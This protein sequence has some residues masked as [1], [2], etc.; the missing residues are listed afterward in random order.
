MSDG[1]TP[2]PTFGNATRFN[3]LLAP[4]ERADV[5]IDFRG[6][7]N[8]NLILYGDA[9]APF[10]GG[11]IRNDYY[12]GVPDLTGIG[13]APTPGAGRSP[14]T[15]TIMQFRVGDS[16]GSIS[17]LDFAGTIAALQND[18]TG[19]PYVF[20]QSQPDLL[21]PTGKFVRQLT[22]NEGFD[23]WGRLIQRLGTTVAQPVLNN[24]GLTEYGIPLDDPPT[25]ITSVGQTEVWEIFNLTGD[26]HPIHFHLVNVQILDRQAFNV[27]TPD[28]T[29][30]GRL[31]TA[32]PP[33]PNEMGW[34]ETVRMN[35]GE[36]IRVIQKFDLPK[37]PFSMTNNLSTRTGILGSEYVW[38][39][40][41]LEH[42]EHDMMRPLIVQGRYPLAVVPEKI[43]TRDCKDVFHIVNGVPPYT[44]T[45]DD[46]R[47]I[48]IPPKV[49]QSGGTF[50]VFP[51]GGLLFLRDHVV[52]LK[53]KDKVGN[54][55]TAKVTVDK[56]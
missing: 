46:W 51:L 54:I 34:K 1:K 35:P 24:Q 17:E 23:N 22:L 39:C 15:R 26:V 14:D 40:H 43:V 25:E 19:L 32:R 38:H 44:V 55:V 16:S 56:P 20:R 11:D 18:A 6:F 27:T 45:T 4:A 29:P 53:I 41:I 49:N 5:I 12:P 52:T 9:P 36:V 31:G 30:A 2:N 48:P 47:L 7:E 3:L 13:G 37:V 10:P 42:E 33:D 8:S 50:M 28:F 21:D